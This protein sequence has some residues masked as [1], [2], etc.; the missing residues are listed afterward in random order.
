MRH[1]HIRLVGN[2]CKPNS[3]PFSSRPRRQQV[4]PA[5]SQRRR[6]ALM[7]AGLFPGRTPA[8]DVLARL[9]LLEPT[10]QMTVR[11]GGGLMVLL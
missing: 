7:H 9:R 11:F 5:A 1:L 4:S 10:A 8:V 2:A 3:P 6:K